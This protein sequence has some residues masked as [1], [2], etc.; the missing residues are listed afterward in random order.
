MDL[1]RWVT[2][3]EVLCREAGELLLEKAAGLAEIATEF[4]G[5]CELVT[6]ADRAAEELVVR[7]LLEQF[8][9]HG[10]LA[11][12]GVLTPKGQVDKEGAEFV[13]ILDPIDGTTNFVHGLPNY[14]VALGLRQGSEMVA[15]VVHAPALQRTYTA[16]AGGGA[17]CDGKSIRVTETA[18]VRDS[19]VATGFSYD[20]NEPGHDDNLGKIAAVLPE[21]RDLRRFG[22]AELDLCQVAAGHYDGYWEMYLMP[23]DVAAGAVIV[24]E[25]GGRVTDLS[26]GDDWL[27]GRQVLAT[28]GRI[29][30]DML[31]LLASG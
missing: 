2:A 17:S 19:L 23:Y 15:G 27:F 10:V 22:S 7:G 6:A 28:N 25:A 9:D 29:H 21:C 5:R 1:G 11:E 18:T 4:K 20:R 3:A 14:C 26:G 12:E 24:R 16:W 31:G 8:P 13:A 30:D